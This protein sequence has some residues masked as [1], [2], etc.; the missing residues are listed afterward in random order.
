MEVIGRKIL[1]P[2]KRSRILS[3]SR[4]PLDSKPGFAAS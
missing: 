2:T 3:K 1:S 4:A